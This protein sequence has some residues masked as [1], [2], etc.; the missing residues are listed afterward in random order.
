MTYK[1][2][3]CGGPVHKGSSKGAQ[4]PASGWSAF[5]HGLTPVVLSTVSDSIAILWPECVLTRR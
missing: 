2:P 3:R 5:T 4:L 1:C